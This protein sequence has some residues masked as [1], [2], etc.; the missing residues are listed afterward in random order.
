MKLTGALRYLTILRREN[1][2]L[3]EENVR[4]QKIIGGM[5]DP[6]IISSDDE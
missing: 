6:S 2:A 3:K 5:L 1:E 4:L